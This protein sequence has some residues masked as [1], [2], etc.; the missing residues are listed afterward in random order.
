MTIHH[1]STTPS[2]ERVAEV[3]EQLLATG[4][5]P[6]L[7]KV[8]EALGGGS[9]NTILEHLRA[10]KQK[11]VQAANPTPEAQATLHETTKRLYQ[12]ALEQARQDFSLQLTRTEQERDAALTE[13]ERRELELEAL[14]DEH[15]AIQTK[16]LQCES[17][18]TSLMGE[19]QRLDELSRCLERLERLIAERC[20]TLAVAGQARDDRL[21]AAQARVLV[22]LTDLEAKLANQGNATSA[23]NDRLSD[24]QRH[25]ANAWEAINAVFRQASADAERLSRHTQQEQAL[26]QQR[27]AAKIDRLEQRLVRKPARAQSHPTCR[28]VLRKTLVMLAPRKLC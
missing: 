3:A 2:P 15:S 10:W 25:Q 23:I 8:R 17:R 12:A 16:L 24:L 6:S 9:P 28:P 7:R 18:L 11:R 21:M 4:Q 20:D 27:L 13:A 22:G 19:H 1:P 14:R 5:T 26:M